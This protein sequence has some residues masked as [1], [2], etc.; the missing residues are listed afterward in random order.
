M[1]DAGNLV[2]PIIWKEHKK[3]PKWINYGSN[4]TLLKGE[5]LGVK[6][7]SSDSSTHWY[8]ASKI[9]NGQFRHAKELYLVQNRTKI[10]CC[11]LHSAKVGIPLT[12]AASTK[13]CSFHPNSRS[14]HVGMFLQRRYV[15]GICPVILGEPVRDWFR[16]LFFPVET[17][18]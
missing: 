5:C 7:R 11:Y 8:T 2:Y 9:L 15:S 4:S 13:R 12:A 1:I 17:I 10:V 16:Q 14:A 3:F 18:P 6:I